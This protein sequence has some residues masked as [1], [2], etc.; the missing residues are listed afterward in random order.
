MNLG[1]RQVRLEHWQLGQF[2]AGCVARKMMD[3]PTALWVL[4]PW[5]PYFLSE[6]K[7]SDENFLEVRFS[8]LTGFRQDCE[9]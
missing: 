3:L 8:S 5:V 6:V 1:Q 4:G 2:A 7:I 9:V